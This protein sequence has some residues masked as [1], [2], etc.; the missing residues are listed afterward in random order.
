MNAVFGPALATMKEAGSATFGP[1]PFQAY[2]SQYFPQLQVRT[3]D[4][5]SVDDRRRLAPELVAADVM[6]LRLGQAAGLTDF[7][8]VRGSGG[9]DDYFLDE[10][11][12]D[13]HERTFLSRA[14]QR[15]LYVFELLPRHVEASLINLAFASGLMSHGLGLDAP[16][17]LPPPARGSSTYTFDVRPHSALEVTWSHRSGQIEID[18]LFVAE[19]G[20]RDVLFVVEA[21]IGSAARP[22]AKHKL[23]YPILGLAPHV[24]MD[25]EIVP[26]Y[27]KMAA[28]PS[29]VLATV[30]ECSLPDP[31]VAL[32]AINDLTAVRTTK[33]RFPIRV[34]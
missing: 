8:L 5:I 15:D 31:R 13:S 28:T 29:G 6:V 24:P 16:G 1:T 10:V 12:L 3:V 32:P 18:A 27:L 2:V 25:I 33:L 9:L 30:V 22:L 23:V 4:A 26:V 20:N 17:G 7:A 11:S 19:R 21:K 14:S 34:G